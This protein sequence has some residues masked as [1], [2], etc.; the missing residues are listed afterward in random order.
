MSFDASA[1]PLFRRTEIGPGGCWLWQGATDGR[2]GYGSV[3]HEG[4]T[5]RAHKVAWELANQKAVPNGMDVC[6]S[7]DTP[8]CINPSHLFLGT[9]QQN[10]ED[11]SRKGRISHKRI[12]YNG[13]TLSIQQWADRIGV[14]RTTLS[15]RLASGW[16]VDRA[17]TYKPRTLTAP[18]SGATND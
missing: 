4:R 12:T 10:M 13:E 14:G 6:H 3:R 1:F 2:R 18:S 7:C 15:Q 11:C 5:R 8:A 16:S 9:R 17:L